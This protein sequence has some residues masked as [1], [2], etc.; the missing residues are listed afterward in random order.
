MNTKILVVCH[1][2]INRSPVCGYLLAQML[3]EAE[4]RQ[5][6]M[7]HVAR[8]EKATKKA[9]DYAAG[10]A[11]FYATAEQRGLSEAWRKI[12]GKL[13]NHRSRQ[14]TAEDLTWADYI[15]YM[16]GGNLKRIQALAADLPKSGKQVCLASHLTPPK[17]RIA[18][19]AFMRAGS[20]EVG[21]TFME[22]FMATQALAK[23]L[24]KG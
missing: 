4:V 7:K 18:D 1:G 12:S 15:I 14:C 9:R 17:N 3:P 10:T 22:I 20:E 24:R 19:P 13:S 5:A 6:A 16:D 2:N 11:L 21:Q 23:T 8:P